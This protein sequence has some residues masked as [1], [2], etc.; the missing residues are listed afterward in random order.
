MPLGSFGE[1]DGRVL[2]IY[3]V[4]KAPNITSRYVKMEQ[5]G[6]RPLYLMTDWPWLLKIVSPSALLIGRVRGCFRDQDGDLDS[7]D[8]SGIVHESDNRATAR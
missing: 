2:L 1:S 3:A 8:R 7:D 5:A 4:A 6:L